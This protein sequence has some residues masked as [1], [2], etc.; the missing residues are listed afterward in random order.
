MD[1]S[2]ARKHTFDPTPQNCFQYFSDELFNEVMTYT[3]INIAQN[4][5]TYSQERA[6]VQGYL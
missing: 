6:T 4:A 1:M 5:E 3:S 2:S